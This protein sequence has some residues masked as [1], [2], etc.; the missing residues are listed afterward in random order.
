MALGTSPT[1][2]CTCMG[3]ASPART[4]PH[5]RV[6]KVRG[7][8]ALNYSAP[9]LLA[10]LVE[11]HLTDQPITAAAP[12]GSLEFLDVGVAAAQPRRGE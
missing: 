12:A 1:P 5:V 7:A 11:A 4:L 10:A 3:S 6:V 2:S 9:T 8:H